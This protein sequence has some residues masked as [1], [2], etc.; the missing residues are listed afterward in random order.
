MFSLILVWFALVTPAFAQ[1]V[2]FSVG[3]EWEGG[4][5]QAS[6]GGTT[7][8][9]IPPTGSQTIDT[10]STAFTYGTFGQIR[11]TA[12]EG[13]SFHKWANIT[14]SMAGS[15]DVKL[16]VSFHAIGVSPG[17]E[18]VAVESNGVY[19][20][21]AQR[22]TFTSGNT[23]TYELR[24]RLTRASLIVPQTVTRICVDEPNSRSPVIFDVISPEN[25]PVLTR[26]NTDGEVIQSA[27]PGKAQLYDLLGFC[28]VTAAPRIL[29]IQA[30]G[31]GPTTFQLVTVRIPIVYTATPSDVTF[32][33]TRG[34]A[35]PQSQT[36]LLAGDPQKTTAW[37]A[38][39]FDGGWLSVTPTN[40][41]FV[42]GISTT[43]QLTLTPDM[44][45]K[46]AGFH[47]SVIRFASGLPSGIGATEPTTAEVRVNFYVA[48]E[49]GSLTTTPSP[50]NA[51]TISLPTTPLV[52]GNKLTLEARPNPGYSFVRWSGTLTST[53]NP[54]DFVLNGRTNLT[55][56][57]A[58]TG[59]G[60]SIILSPT[61]LQAP[62]SGD[63]GRID[64]TTANNCTWDVTQLPSWLTIRKSAN[65]LNY[66]IDPNP[67]AL[68]RQATLLIGN[69]PL[70]VRQ[71][72]ESCSS[73][74]LQRPDPFDSTTSTRN[75]TVTAD[76][77]CSYIAG[78][79]ETWL[80]AATSALAGDQTLPITAQPNGTGAP[81][82]STC[83]I[84][85]QRLAILQKP[86]TPV[87]PYTDVT[88]AHS[89]GEYITLLQRNNIADT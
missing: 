3:L 32:S 23:A 11:V 58:Y 15:A 5:T 17:Y 24:A 75:V 2:T 83:F 86:V 37:V 29:S 10:S 67:S 89:L 48:D 35:P 66:R 63:L 71:V 20:S 61:L 72:G 19:F 45:T 87:L 44:V 84:G 4:G 65:Y 21:L 7:M 41:N 88:A 31:V 51:G 64:V 14:I 46:S 56:E 47:S 76:P 77:A 34:Q 40:G 12:S 54:L 13:S 52:N 50:T 49:P 81:R 73:L 59:A 26:F 53:A 25:T 60:C 8:E 1:P 69:A 74:R 36:V 28:I 18:L 22:P 68:T 33:Y 42:A 82:L 39:G 57:F 80:S 16:A 85:G 30:E 62:A 38:S 55:A 6:S 9:L 43:R 79:S 70:D 27:G 78:R